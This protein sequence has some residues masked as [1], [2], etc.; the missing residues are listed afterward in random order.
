[1][2][3]LRHAVGL[4]LIVNLLRVA[5]VAQLPPNK[6]TVAV[7]VVT[8]SWENALAV[9]DAVVEYNVFGKNIVAEAWLDF[10]KTTNMW[11]KLPPLEPGLW[12]FHVTA[13]NKWGLSSNPSEV[14]A[15]VQVSAFTFP[16]APTKVQGV[17]TNEITIN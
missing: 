3:I 5:L 2:K 11:M 10:G 7:T 1:M 9:E 6:A 4:L 12:H 17:V 14:S 13:I 15:P 8:V 16:R